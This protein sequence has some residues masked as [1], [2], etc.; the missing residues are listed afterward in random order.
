MQINV[1]EVEANR[2]TSAKLKSKVEKYEIKM[3]ARK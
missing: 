2:S 1:V 3:K